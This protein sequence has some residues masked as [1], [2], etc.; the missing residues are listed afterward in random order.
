MASARVMV[1]SVEA[2]AESLVRVL[3]HAR[4][5]RKDYE[6]GPVNSDSVLRSGLF[7]DGD[8]EEVLAEVLDVSGAIQVQ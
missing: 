5:T 6:F 3:E 1:D 7:L 8:I 4:K 2:A